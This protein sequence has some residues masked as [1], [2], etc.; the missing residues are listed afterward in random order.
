MDNKVHIQIHK[1][2]Q[3]R[4]G[5]THWCEGDAVQLTSKLQVNK[6]PLTSML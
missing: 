5:L 4:H 3:T 2:V 6:H 1:L